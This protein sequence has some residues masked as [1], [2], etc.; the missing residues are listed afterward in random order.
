MGSGSMRGSAGRTQSDIPDA[1]DTVF[2][3][4]IANGKVYVAYG[5]IDPKVQI[6]A[7]IAIRAN[8]NKKAEQAEDDLWSGKI[9]RKAYD[10]PGNLR[11]KCENEYMPLLHAKCAKAA[12]SILCGSNPAGRKAACDGSQYALSRSTLALARIS[13][14]ASSADRFRMIF[15]AICGCSRR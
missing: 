8:I 13:R 15:I 12:R 9:D 3:S 10:K 6:P 14:R 4:A 1:A 7:C 5:S 2:V 11:Q